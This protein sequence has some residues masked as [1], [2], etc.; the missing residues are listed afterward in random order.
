M[1][2][3][4]TT[5][6][7]RRHLVRALG[8][9][10]KWEDSTRLLRASFWFWRE[11]A[12]KISGKAEVPPARRL[13]WCLRLLDNPAPSEDHLAA[14]AERISHLDIDAQHYWIGTLYTLLLPSS[15]EGRTQHILRRLIWLAGYCL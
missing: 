7:A 3:S 9:A 13:T 14:F 12:A 15:C 6:V 10:W 8:D 4:I 5:S 1:L 2:S 11:T